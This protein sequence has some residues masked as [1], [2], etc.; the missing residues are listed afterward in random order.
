MT[1]EDGASEHTLTVQAAEDVWL[2][3]A[4]QFPSLPIYCVQVVFVPVYEL[5]NPKIVTHPNPFVIQPV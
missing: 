1:V 3:G 2:E 4:V 5:H